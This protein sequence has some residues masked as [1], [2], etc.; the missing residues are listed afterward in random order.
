MEKI[1][2]LEKTCTVFIKQGGEVCNRLKSGT[3]VTA[4][5]Q[6]DGWIKITWRNGKKKGWIQ[7]PS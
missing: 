3:R 6:R 7:T 1:I 5:Q 4:V 2:T